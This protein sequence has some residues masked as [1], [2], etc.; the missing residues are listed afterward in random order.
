MSKSPFVAPSEA[1]QAWL[2]GVAIAA[3]QPR[4]NEFQI[5]RARSD[6]DAPCPNLMVVD[7]DP[8]VRQQLYRLYAQSGYSVLALSS[9]E[10]ALHRLEADD[11]DFVITDIKLPGMDGVQFI[12]RTC[13]KYPELPVIAITGYADIQIAV[14]VLKLGARDFVSK[15]FDLGAVLESTRAALESSRASMEIRQLR[16]W[17]KERYQFS[18]MLSQTPQMQRVFELIRL[19]APN[20]TTVLVHGEPGTGK[21]LVAHAIH[22][23]SERRDGPFVAVSC[24]DFSEDVLES[25]LFGREA[26][27]TQ[28]S[29]AAKPG[30][31]AMAHGG[32]LFIDEIDSLPLALQELMLR[33]IEERKLRRVSAAQSVPV[34]IR[35]VA[36]SS[37]TLKARV[38]EGT[39]RVDFYQRIHALPIHLIPLRECQIDIPLLIQNYLQDDPVA[40]SKRI[41]NVSSK[42]LGQLMEYSW[43]GNIRELQN[44]LDRAIMLAPSRI[45]ENV[46]LPEAPFDPSRE[47]SEIAASGSL[48]QWLREKEKFY[49][50]QKL[51]DFDGN[52]GLTAKTCRIG[53]RTL[54]RKMRTYGLDKKLFKE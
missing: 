49:I 44:V 18:E 15:P 54:S 11:V 26:G 22:H 46:T 32:T 3:P 10:E 40:Q 9:A 2:H 24:A 29:G 25:E 35:V 21:E 42:V 34:D 1:A 45:I 51:E 8:G 30:K 31:I 41:V 43:P 23:R 48:R 5:V 13:Q 28:G 7:D 4:A 53:V 47:K 17:L 52:V 6:N 19:A 14:D 37:A 12:S 33:V 27:A 39:M 16:R 20:D 38:T 50:A 36:G